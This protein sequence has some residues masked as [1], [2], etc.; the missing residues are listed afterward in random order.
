VTAR[1][2]AVA[3][4]LTLLACGRGAVEPPARTPAS[5]SPTGTLEAVL[6]TASCPELRDRLFALSS[7]EQLVDTW[8]WVKRCVASVERD[9]LGLVAD[10]YVWN[11]VDRDYGAVGIHEFLHAT[12]HAEIE[13]QARA[14]YADGRL[15]VTLTTKPHPTISVE[16]VGALDL[17]PLNWASLLVI[18]LAPALGASP[19]ALAKGKVREE[20]ETTLET[21]LATPM[22]VTYD[23]RRGTFSFGG[24]HEQGPSR[25][26]RIAPR[27][28]ALL[29]PFP[30]I[31]PGS[32]ARVRLDAGRRAL[33]RAVC[34]T[35]AERL[36]DADRRG[37]PVPA[38]EWAPAEADARLALPAMPC[39]WMLALRA[40][41][42]VSGVVVDTM[43]E[44]APP[45]VERPDRWVSIDEAAIDREDLDPDVDIVI[46]GDGFS[47]QVFPPGKSAFPSIAVLA[48]DEHL[49]L[50]ARRR[51]SPETI[52]AARLPVDEPGD[53]AVPIALTAI[54]GS[55]VAR[56][57]VRARVRIG[58]RE[59]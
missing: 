18:E 30:A 9:H 38:D 8:V 48:P 11:A 50:R 5:T 22:E 32:S 14:R 52:A 29:G 27:G 59:P 2:L 36:V 25:R 21:S 13:L 33:V 10:A 26:L 58:E 57:A 17:A 51:S 34:R 55:P 31:G 53:V 49:W 15:T 44:P 42:R 24:A 43:I 6:A 39:E 46:A 45:L 3:S 12:V 47:A 40:T 54:D 19:E 28:T 16:P 56:V 37:D 1:R 35:H 20:V 41:D 4:L 23:A 7:D